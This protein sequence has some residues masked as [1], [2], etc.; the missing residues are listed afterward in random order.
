KSFRPG[1]GRWAAPVSPAQVPSAIWVRSPPGL[2]CPRRRPAPGLGQRTQR[3]RWRI[4]TACLNTYD[5]YRACFSARAN[6]LDTL[7]LI[8]AL[9]SLARSVSRCLV[10]LTFNSESRGQKL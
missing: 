1:G 7:T 6:G 9:N 3:G 10:V 8:I 5:L 4:V 2:A